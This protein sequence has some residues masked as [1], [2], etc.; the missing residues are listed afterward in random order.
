M[1]ELHVAAVSEDGRHVLLAT[2][3]GAA[4]GEFRVALDDRLAA[5]LRGDLPRPGESTTPVV[6]LS[7]KEIQARLRAGE[8][9]EQ[10]AA[11]AGLPVARVERF[12]GPVLSERERIINAAR[13]AV[14]ARPRRGPSGLP[15]G[16][17]VAQH[18]SEAVGYRPETTTWSARREESGRWVVQLSFVARAKTRTAAWR[19]DPT[20]RELT[21]L[22]APS[23]VLGHVEPTNG[24]RSAGSAWP[25]LPN[26]L[27]PPRKARARPAKA[28]VV[29]AAPAAKATAVRAPAATTGPV[30]RTAAA[31]RV[32]G[33]TV[34]APGSRKPLARPAGPAPAARAAE[35]DAAAEAAA[36]AAAQAE[37]A[38]AATQAAEAV[39]EAQA[40]AAARA[41]ETAAA[42]EVAA[43]TQAAAEAVAA[44]EAAAASHA[45]EAAAIQA[46]AEAAAE[47]AAKEQ[48]A[49][50]QAAQAAAAEP[51][52]PPGPPTLRVVPPAKPAPRA[53]PARR[54]AGSRA[55][56]P[57]WAD[58]L[59]G[60][61]PIERSED[62]DKGQD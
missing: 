44:A 48:A 53:V 37:E 46:V 14:L 25:T 7:P 22:D 19:Y 42:A 35:V 13:G 29:R 39:A 38:A 4:R 27:A 52:A 10:I 36:A 40:A 47:Q 28:A 1:R 32:P 3:K 61:A 20:T 31:G 6:V 60:I 17:A 9:S 45:A 54:A 2:R 15:L 41:A 49:Q 8:S 18:L 11:S 57:A 56:V 21:S 12:A 59:L 34:S 16:E 30:T 23:A 62:S 43:A 55:S 5:A 26:P 33:R 51:D 24:Q 58:V 50:V